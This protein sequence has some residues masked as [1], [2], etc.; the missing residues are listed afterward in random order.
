MLNLDS[1]KKY[2]LACS[3]GP[4]S[5]ALFSMLLKGKYSFDVAHVNYHL[6]KE[7]NYE[8]EQLEAFCF[9]HSTKLF[10]LDN[11]NVPKKNIEAEC[12]EIRYSFFQNLFEQNGYD[13]LLVAHQQDD[14]IE[15]YLMQKDRKNLPK[16]YGI[17]EKTSIKGM[18]VLRP[19]LS[20]RKDELL[21]HCKENNVPYAIDITNLQPL[22]KRNKIRIDIVSKLSNVERQE[23]LEKIDN[24]NKE[25]SKILAKVHKTSNN[26]AEI[27]ALSD[28]ELAY[29]LNEKV[30]KYCQNNPITYKQSLEVR[31]ML[32][33]EKP[34]VLI[35]CCKDKVVIEKAY[36]KLLVRENSISDK[37]SFAVGSP[38]IIDNEY[39][40]AD[41][42][43]DP[44]KRNIKESD[45][46]LVIRSARKGDKYK[47]KDYEVSVRRLFIDWK[48]PLYLRK[49]WPIF[50]NRHGTI[51]YI[52]RYRKDFVIESSPYFYVKERF[53]LK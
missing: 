13:A 12:R 25:V 45:Y 1:E 18:T 22:Y 36:T 34:N 20:Y 37:Y 3:F 39:L 41:L 42:V 15:T 48:M 10:V 26:I 14:H 21:N 40:Y 6:R 23:L 9:E 29:F 43:N 4:D 27:L 11:L 19:L 2:L 33:S 46:P 47:I 8:Q 24:K 32:T 17:S 38:T 53:T 31:K 7:S 49:L 52:P 35:C 50:V 51:I 5:M 30:R 28:I 44:N 16:F